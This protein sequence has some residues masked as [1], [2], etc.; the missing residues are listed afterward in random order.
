[1]VSKISVHDGWSH[2]SWATERHTSLCRE[3][4]RAELLTSWLTGSRERKRNR[5][6][7]KRHHDTLPETYFLQAFLIFHHFLIIYSI[8][9]LSRKQNPHDETIWG[10][11]LHQMRLLRR[12]SYQTSIPVPLKEQVFN[13]HWLKAKLCVCIY[14][15]VCV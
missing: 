14:V 6:S 12:Y 5:L 7:N 1:M 15:C 9:N 4:D 11:Y 8:T 13:Q 2:Y 3:Y 10:L